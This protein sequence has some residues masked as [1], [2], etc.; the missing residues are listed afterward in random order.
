[1]SVRDSDFQASLYSHFKLFG[2]MAYSSLEF[3]VLVIPDVTIRDVLVIHFTIKIVF[4]N[5]KDFIFWNMFLLI[6]NL[7]WPS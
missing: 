3:M 7:L 2:H 6:F 5:R 4:V 1:M